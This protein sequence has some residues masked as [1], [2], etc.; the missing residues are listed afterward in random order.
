MASQQNG[1]WFHSSRRG[2]TDHVY[3]L[4]D[5]QT[6]SLLLFLESEPG[7]APCQFP[8]LGDKDSIRRDWQ[9]SIPKYNIY[10]DRWERKIRFRNYY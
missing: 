7:K 1:I 4:K 6:A 9:I 3:A 5:E 10:R 2:V 8:V